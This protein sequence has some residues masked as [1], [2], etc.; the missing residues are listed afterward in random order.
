MQMFVIEMF[1]PQMLASSIPGFKIQ[2]D[3]NFNM[4][5]KEND[6]SASRTSRTQRAIALKWKR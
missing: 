1:D 6:L 2:R 3:A 5:N 4:T